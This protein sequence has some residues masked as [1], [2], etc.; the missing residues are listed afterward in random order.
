MVPVDDLFGM[1]VAEAR[2]GTLSLYFEDHLPGLP[3]SSPSSLPAIAGN[4]P[5]PHPHPRQPSRPP[6]MGSVL[7][8]SDEAFE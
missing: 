2:R 5:R 3:E 7:L 8:V 6:T 1:K 4:R